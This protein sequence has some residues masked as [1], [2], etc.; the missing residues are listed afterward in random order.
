M[1]QVF[2]QDHRVKI[3]RLLDQREQVGDTQQDVRSVVAPP[4]VRGQQQSP[5]MSC[6]CL[7]A[8]QGL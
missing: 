1:D 3:Q 2:R 8:H 6:R 7:R 4:L 5:S